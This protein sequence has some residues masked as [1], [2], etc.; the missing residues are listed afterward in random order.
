MCSGL[1]LRNM[2]T[3]SGCCVKNGLEGVRNKATEWRKQTK[4]IFGKW[5]PPNHQGSSFHFHRKLRL[6]R[7]SDL[8]KGSIAIKQETKFKLPR[9]TNS[10]YSILCKSKLPVEV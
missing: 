3:A 6:K 1:H 8:P 2:I 10:K 5:S 9:T 7:V 4:E